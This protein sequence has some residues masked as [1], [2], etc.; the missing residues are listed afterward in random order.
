M[1]ER[2][3]EHRD[4]TYLGSEVALT[5]RRATIDC[6]VRNLSQNGAKLSFT[7]PVKVRGE[8]AL[9]IH[10]KGVSRRARV[11]WQREKEAGIAFVASAPGIVVSIETARRLKRLETEVDALARRVAALDERA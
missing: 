4:R 9:T 3:E 2:R 7:E 6:L 1:Q 11:V 10:Q 8:F 5:E